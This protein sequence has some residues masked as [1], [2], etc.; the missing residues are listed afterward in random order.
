M[1]VSLIDV[2]NIELENK[3]TER[4][5]L[6][7]ERTTGGAVAINVTNSSCVVAIPNNFHKKKKPLMSGAAYHSWYIKF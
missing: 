6:L 4:V 2:V 3:P 5:R 7:K 1:S